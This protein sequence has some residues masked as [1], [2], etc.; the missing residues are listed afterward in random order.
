MKFIVCDLSHSQSMTWIKS[1]RGKH[2]V[3]G[4]CDSSHSLHRFESCNTVTRIMS[5]TD[6]NHT[7]HISHNTVWFESH[8]QLTRIIMLSVFFLFGY[9]QIGLDQAFYMTRIMSIHDSNHERSRL[10]SNLQLTWIIGTWV[11]FIY[12]ILFHFTWSF[13]SNHEMFLTQI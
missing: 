3:F 13:E 10:R 12:E 9:V 4:F 5:Y 7:P 8:F 2:E 6:L 1:N 11:A